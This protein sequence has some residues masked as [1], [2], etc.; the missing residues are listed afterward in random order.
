M[1]HL[2]SNGY[3]LS[4]SSLIIL[5]SGVKSVHS[6]NKQVRTK[7]CMQH[8]KCGIL[9]VG[10]KR[11][12]TLLSQQTFFTFT[13][14]V[15][16]YVIQKRI[17]YDPHIC[18]LIVKCSPFNCE[19]WNVVDS[20]KQRNLVNQKTSNKS[21]IE[22]FIFQEIWKHFSKKLKD[23][24]MNLFLVSLCFKNLILFISI[25]VWANL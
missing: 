17:V 22:N 23:S 6:I 18:Y 9:R 15:K 4:P 3:G 13:L 12:P 8:L 20:G 16:L 10:E 1:K 14:N 21:Y 2:V 5:T 11:I 24:N 25:I 19:L 7:H